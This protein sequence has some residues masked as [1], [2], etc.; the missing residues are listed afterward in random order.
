[1]SGGDSKPTRTASTSGGHETIEYQF[2]VEIFVRRAEVDDKAV[3]ALV[4]D[5]LKR[6]GL[7]I[8]NAK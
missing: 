3:R 8:K 6:L 2:K 1:M 5:E 4:D 7:A